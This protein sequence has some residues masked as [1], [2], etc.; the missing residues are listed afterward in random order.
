MGLP[1]GT[2]GSDFVQVRDV[3]WIVKT[4]AI[5]HVLF[6]QNGIQSGV[7]VLSSLQPVTLY[8]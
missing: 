7:L 6:I 5:L 3:F 1:F 8:E 2:A 4:L